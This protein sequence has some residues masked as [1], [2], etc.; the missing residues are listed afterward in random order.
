MSTNEESQDYEYMFKI[1]LI[2]SVGVGKSSLLQRYIENK[3]DNNYFCTIGVDFY[4]KKIK[5]KDKEIKL[6]LWDT[7][8]TEKYRSITTSYYRGAHYACII[9]DLTQME[10]FKNLSQ[11]IE[12][13]YKYCNREFDKNIII[14]GNKNDLIKERVV[15]KEQI[16][17]FIKINNFS[18]FETSAKSGENVEECFH[19]IAEKLMEEENRKENTAGKRKVGNNKNLKNTKYYDLKNEKKGCCS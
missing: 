18:Y 2:G 10:T 16:D 14:I 1:I 17:E 4:I 11:W 5:L 3:F 15:S 6:Q 12:T 9:F 19:F 13:Y 8:G 7:A